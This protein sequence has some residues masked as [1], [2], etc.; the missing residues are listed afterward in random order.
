[1]DLWDRGPDLRGFRRSLVKLFGGP[2]VPSP[3]VRRIIL[4][5]GDQRHTLL[6][7]IFNRFVV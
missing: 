6:V 1:M 4:L 5:A 3:V 7:F 2:S